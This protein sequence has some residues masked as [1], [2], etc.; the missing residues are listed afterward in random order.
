MAEYAGI[1]RNMAEYHGENNENIYIMNITVENNADVSTF[2]FQDAVTLEELI[3][4]IQ[5]FW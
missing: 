2:I 4:L 5:N 3:V 1:S